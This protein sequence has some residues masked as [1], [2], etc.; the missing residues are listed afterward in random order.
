MELIQKQDGNYLPANLEDLAQFVLVGRDKLNMVRAGIRALDK[1]DVAEG[2]R[3][4]KR[5]EAQMLAEA[6]LDAEVRIGEIL[7]KMPFGWT[8]SGATA[9]RTTDRPTTICTMYRVLPMALI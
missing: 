6:L 8:S 5:E 9:I 4:Q 2:V 1:L 7:E 3:K